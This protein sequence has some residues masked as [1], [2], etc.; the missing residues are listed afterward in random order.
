MPGRIV[1]TDGDVPPLAAIPMSDVGT[2]PSGPKK[3]TP[4]QVL[5]L[6]PG[7]RVRMIAARGKAAIQVKVVDG[8]H[9]D[10]IGVVPRGYIDYLSAAARA[11]EG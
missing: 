1:A 3:G 4:P 7:T 11:P 2:H 6:S 8:P 10:K 5:F 9:A